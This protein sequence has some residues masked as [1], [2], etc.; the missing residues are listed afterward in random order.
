MDKLASKLHETENA[1]GALE[2]L[3][4]AANVKRG[5]AEVN[6]GDLVQGCHNFELLVAMSKIFQPT[7]FN[8]FKM[9]WQ[10]RWL[11]TKRKSERFVSMKSALENQFASTKADSQPMTACGQHV[12]QLVQSQQKLKATCESKN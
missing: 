10:P 12:S 4:S 8:P 2:G 5:E 6:L 1:D 11:C 9:S 3:L 7:D